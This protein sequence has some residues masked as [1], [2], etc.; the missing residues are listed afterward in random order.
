MLR[1]GA[2]IGTRPAATLPRI[3]LV[4]MMLG[5]S[6]E[7]AVERRASKP[8]GERPAVARFRGLARR[9]GN[10]WLRPRPARGGGGRRG[11]PAR[12]GTDRDGI[13]AV[14]NH[15]AERGEVTVDGA[16]RRASPRRATRSGSASGSARR[17]AR[18][19][20]SSASSSVTR[21]HHPRAPGPQRLAQ[22]IVLR[23]AAGDRLGASSTCSRSARPT[24][25][26]PIE[27]LSGGNQQK[28]LLARGCH[29]A[30]PADPRRADPRHRRRCARRDRA[31]DRA[32]RDDGM[33]LYVISSELTRSSPPM[34]TA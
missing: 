19:T 26:E 18:P 6:L 12:L 32:A 31:P 7:E 23:E 11:G 9:D 27:Q 30:A 4:S 13:D 33:A 15:P 34:P 29:R 20:A 28:A 8:A 16:R 22:A 25:T 3:E 10:R 5:K 14:R 1:N 21:E 17:S 2:L 24:P